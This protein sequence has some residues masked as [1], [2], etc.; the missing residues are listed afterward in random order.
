[1]PLIFVE[2]KKSS[3]N[4]PRS[5]PPR[6]SVDPEGITIPE[7]PVKVVIPATSNP[8]MHLDFDLIDSKF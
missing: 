8:L 1:M 5:L 2:P 3:K 6:Y 4:I 7:V